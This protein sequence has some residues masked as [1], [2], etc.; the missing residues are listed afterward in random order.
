M[1]GQGEEWLSLNPT[2]IHNDLPS[3]PLVLRLPTSSALRVVAF[4]DSAVFF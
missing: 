1:M 2:Q 3:V 4:C